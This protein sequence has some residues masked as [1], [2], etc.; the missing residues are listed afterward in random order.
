M[1][2]VSLDASRGWLASGNNRQLIA[3]GLRGFEKECLRID[4]NGHLS[5]RPHSRHWGSALTHPWITT[6]YSE[7]LLEFVTPPVDCMISSVPAKP[8]SARRPVSR[9]R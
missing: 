4:R 7:A 8:L 9:S 6:D 1:V 2:E 3:A 5:A